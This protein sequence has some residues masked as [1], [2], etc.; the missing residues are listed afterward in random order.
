MADNVVGD[1]APAGSS[2]LEQLE[3][4]LDKVGLM[5]GDYA[6]IKRLVLGGVLGS[7]LV[8]WIKP[9]LMFTDTGKALPWT[10]FADPEE[11]ST[12]LPWFFVPAFFA[13]FFGVLI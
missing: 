10:L 4:L 13:F 8:T 5:T 2:A 11:K 7:L 12:M 1:I 9:R 6:I 3:M